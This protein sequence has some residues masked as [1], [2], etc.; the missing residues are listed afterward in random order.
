[1]ELLINRYCCIWL[2]VYIIASVMN[3]KANT[4]SSNYLKRCKVGWKKCIL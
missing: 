3:S 2:V 1:L 4:K